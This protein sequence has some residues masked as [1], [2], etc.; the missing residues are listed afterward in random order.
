MKNATSLFFSQAPSCRL[1]MLDNHRSHTSLGK[2]FIGESNHIIFTCYRTEKDKLLFFTLFLKKK[3]PEQKQAHFSK[4]EGLCTGT[5][6]LL[7]I[8][9]SNFWEKP[10]RPSQL[11]A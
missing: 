3:K 11:C 5:L 7:C 10:E 8:L 1:M 4:P 9:L 2:K 6:K